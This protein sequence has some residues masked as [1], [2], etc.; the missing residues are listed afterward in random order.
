MK[1][2]L[3]IICLL[4]LLLCSCNKEKNVQP[5]VKF[6]VDGTELLTDTLYPSLNSYVEVKIVSLRPNGNS[7]Y[8]W[9]SI[10]G[11][12][13]NLRSDYANLQIISFEPLYDMNGIREVA[14][15]RMLFNDT[16]YQVGDHYKLK[17]YCGD[18]YERTLDFIIV[19]K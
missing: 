18:M 17:V 10:N 8:S 14:E 13:I 19:S 16:I 3:P 7:D 11:F 15:F 1:R 6:Y 2:I 5:E 9:R 4:V 12:P